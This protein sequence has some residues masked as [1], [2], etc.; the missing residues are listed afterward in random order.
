MSE[1]QRITEPET[2]NLG[3]FK[4]LGK[5]VLSLTTFSFNIGLAVA[6]AMIGVTTIQMRAEEKPAITAAPLTSVNVFRAE[7]QSGYEVR[8]SFVGRLEPARSTD[9]AFELSGTVNSIHVDEGDRIKKGDVVAVLDTRALEAERRQQLANRQATESNRELAF[10][11]LNRRQKLNDN[12]HVSEQGL[13]EARL[14]LTRLDATLAQIDAAIDLIDINLDK[15]VLKAPF[16]GQVG[17]RLLD[18][19]ATTSPGSPVLR[20]LESS[21]PTVRIGLSPE[22]ADRLDSQS[23]YDITIS[24]RSFKARLSALRPDLQTRTRTVETLFSIDDQEISASFGR[25]AELSLSDRVSSEGFWIPLSSLKEGPRGL[26]TVL[27]VVGAGPEEV[28]QI[29]KVARETVEVLHAE[30][31]RVFV[32]GTISPKTQIIRGGVHRVVVGQAVAVTAEGA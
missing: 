15:A 12:G 18:D 27:T 30:A 8:R 17:E 28:E 26:W 29:S 21:S 13:D 22:I 32:R 25:L 31:Y 4:R 7:L 16:D 11:T 9:L 20:L 24:G 3:R 10:L 1:E 6:A 5:M 2:P 23:T 14:T 19:G